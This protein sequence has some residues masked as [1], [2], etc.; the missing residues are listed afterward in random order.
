MAI[1]EMGCNV[2]ASGGYGAPDK[3]HV[4]EAKSFEQKKAELLEQF[5]AARKRKS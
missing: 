5:K 3:K 4:A 2:S 1:I